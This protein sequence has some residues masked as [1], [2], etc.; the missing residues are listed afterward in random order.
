[1]LQDE[2]VKQQLLLYNILAML[3]IQRVVTS[4]E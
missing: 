3:P 1:M 4:L 2:R